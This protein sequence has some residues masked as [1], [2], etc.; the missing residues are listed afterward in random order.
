M[1]N[2]LIL[3][4]FRARGTAADDM[5]HNLQ[6]GVA[7]HDGSHDGYGAGALG[8]RHLR[9]GA[10]AIGHIFHLVAMA[11]DVDEWR[12]ELHQRV[13]AVIEAA[14]IAA[15]QWGHQLETGE[16]LRCGLDDVNN[17]AHSVII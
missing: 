17:F 3:S 8:Q 12:M 5:G 2:P 9:I 15:F 10:V 16:G 1:L 6:C 13:N 7:A 11:G 14:H 4:H